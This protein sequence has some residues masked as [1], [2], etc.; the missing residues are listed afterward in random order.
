MEQD[1]AIKKNARLEA[2]GRAGGR[3]A[4]EWGHDIGGDRIHAKE[5]G[6]EKS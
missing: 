6:I 2:L 5:E 3:A 4:R 1:L